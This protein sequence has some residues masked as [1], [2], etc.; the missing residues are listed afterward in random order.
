MAAVAGMPVVVAV[1]MIAP[2]GPPSPLTEPTMPPVPPRK[3]RSCVE[4]LDQLGD[5]ASWDEFLARVAASADDGTTPEGGDAPPAT[6]DVP[7]QDEISQIAELRR[8][9]GLD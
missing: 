4:I 5:R 8:R 1:D 3:P 2:V 9:L 6:S 7:G